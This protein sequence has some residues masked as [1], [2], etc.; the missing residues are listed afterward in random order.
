MDHAAV[1]AELG[2]KPHEITDVYDAPDGVVA[3]W[4]DGNAVQRHLVEDRDGQLKVVWRAVQEPDLDDDGAV[5]V[6]EVVDPTVPATPP[7]SEDDAL[8]AEL[9]AA[10][11]AVPEAE[12]EAFVAALADL[13]DLDLDDEG[14][15][16]TAGDLSKDELLELAASQNITVDGR[17][18]VKKLRSALGL[19]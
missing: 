6:G 7:P 11:D 1:C 15:G 10:I 13:A 8:L 9:Q 19:D 4:H 12:R 3:I 17:W 5:R 14:D 2:A 18:G 16:S